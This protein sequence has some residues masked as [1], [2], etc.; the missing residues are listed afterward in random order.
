MNLK[1]LIALSIISIGLISITGCFKE[2]TEPTVTQSDRITLNLTNP[3]PWSN[4]FGLVEIRAD[5]NP[6]DI[7]DH[8]E[9]YLDGVLFGADSFSPYAVN[10]N[11]NVLG[12]SYTIFVRAIAKDGSSKDSPMITVF[13]RPESDI[14]PPSVW[15]TSPAPWVAVADSIEIFAEATDNVQ[16]AAVVMLL[17]GVLL[18]SVSAAPYRFLWDTSLDTAGNHTLMA[19]AYDNA[20]NIGYSDL[21]IVT[22]QP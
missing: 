16:V 15:I 18:D 10:W 6:V 19:K 13:V 2:G 4:V 21:V 22:V 9:F 17:D 14:E 3:A 11:A 5:I 1:K 20:G 12:Q 8:V 7:I